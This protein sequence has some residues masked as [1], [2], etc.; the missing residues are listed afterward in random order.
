MNIFA[1]STPNSFAF[2]LCNNTPS[3]IS[4]YQDAKKLTNTY[5]LSKKFIQSTYSL[6]QVQLLQEGL[7]FLEQ[8]F[9]TI[10]FIASNPS[11]G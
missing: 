2:N 9:L 5:M 7:L 6:A 8:I 10:N 4:D 3:V 1:F 11:S